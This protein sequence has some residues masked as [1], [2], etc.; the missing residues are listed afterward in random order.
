MVG[1]MRANIDVPGLDARSKH[2]VGKAEERGCQRRAA[3]QANAR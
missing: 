2:A 1:L 3:F